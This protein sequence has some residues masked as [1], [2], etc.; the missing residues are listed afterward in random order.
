VNKT[1]SCR[2]GSG[3][4][5]FALPNHCAHEGYH[6]VALFQ[7]LR[8]VW[9]ESVIPVNSNKIKTRKPEE[10]TCSVRGHRKKRCVHR[11][12]TRIGSHSR[13]GVRLPQLPGVSDTNRGTTVVIQN[14]TKYLFIVSNY[15]KK[16]YIF[17]KKLNTI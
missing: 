10:F 5:R 15:Y 17:K 11:M 16:K 9:I 4:W 3:W 1:G 2:Y 7:P 14:D 6:G 13:L 8:T 12:R